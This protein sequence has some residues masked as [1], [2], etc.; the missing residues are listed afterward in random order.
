MARAQ[1]D[2]NSTKDQILSCAARLFR[3]QGYAAVTLRE[4]AKSIGMTTGSLYYHFSSKEEIVREI[5]DQGHKRVFTEVSQA[6]ENLGENAP[7][8]SILKTG[9]LKHVECLLGEDSFPSANTRIFAH[10][11]I[12]V[13]APTLGDRHNYEIYWVNLIRNCQKRGAIR[14]DLD[15]HMLSLLL[16]GAMNWTLEWFKPGRYSIEGIANDL[17]KLVLN[18]NGP[19]SSP[20]ATER[21][22]RKARQAR[23]NPVKA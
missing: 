1:V 20:S 15:P 4:I 8:S 12:E 14:E 16:F 9:I 2:E 7:C 22:P 10:V 6:I 19:T 23:L 18:G 11:P 5:L 21:S 17:T 13:R 3:T